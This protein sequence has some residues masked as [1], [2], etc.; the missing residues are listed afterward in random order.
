MLLSVVRHDID[1]GTNLAE[2]GFASQHI[3][4]VIV[5][6]SDTREMQHPVS[7]DRSIRGALKNVQIVHVAAELEC[8]ANNLKS[9]F[10]LV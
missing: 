7:V 3:N 8:F 9:I 10:L 5:E 4:L 2:R 6:I 1:T